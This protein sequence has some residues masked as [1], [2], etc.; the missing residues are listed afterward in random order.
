MSIQNIWGLEKT[1][2]MELRI[3]DSAFN[4]NRQFHT[5]GKLNLYTYQDPSQEKKHLHFECFLIHQSSVVLSIDVL[6]HSVVVSLFFHCCFLCF[7]QHQHLFILKK[8]HILVSQE[9]NACF[10]CS[11][12][13]LYL[14]WQHLVHEIVELAAINDNI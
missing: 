4:Y 2:L 11:R 9:R 1:E 10:N 8:Y 14:S 13:Y 6:L 5:I 3:T 12:Y 7:Y